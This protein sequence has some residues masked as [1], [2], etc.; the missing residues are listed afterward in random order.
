MRRD[1]RGKK[2]IKVNILV[3]IILYHELFTLRNFASLQEDNKPLIHTEARECHMTG[4][5]ILQLAF[6]SCAI[7]IMA[8]PEGES[9]E[10]WLSELSC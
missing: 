5:C 3:N 10:S 2:Y 4:M 1:V 9:L 6:V 7:V 8:D